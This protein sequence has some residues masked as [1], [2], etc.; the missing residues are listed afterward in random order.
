MAS[1]KR[2][3]TLANTEQALHY[4]DAGEVNVRRFTYR[5]QRATAINFTILFVDLGEYLQHSS[6]WSIICSKYL[7]MYIY[8]L[9]F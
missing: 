2:E 8:Q 7:S 5:I 9:V 3:D 1:D 6:L 4:K